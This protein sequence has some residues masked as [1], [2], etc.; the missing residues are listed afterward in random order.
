MRQS[1][2]GGGRGRRTYSAVRFG[3]PRT[4][5]GDAVFEGGLFDGADGSFLPSH[6]EGFVGVAL[7]VVDW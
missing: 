4:E 1:R 5:I 7:D 3:A 6:V 2:E